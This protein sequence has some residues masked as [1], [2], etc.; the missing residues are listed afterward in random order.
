WRTDLEVHNPGSVQAAYTVG[1]LKRD[2]DNT[3][4]AVVSF[5]LAPGL[6]QRYTDI[7]DTV[8]H[9]S[10][11]A[12]LQIVV[13]SG[14]L[15]VASDTYNRLGAGNPGGLPEGSTYGQ[16][17]PAMTADQAI[18]SSDQ[19]RIIQLSHDPGMST[20]FRTNL[21]LVNAGTMP[22]A[23]TVE[24]Y[25]SGG[26]PLGATI[27]VSLRGL[28]Y[29][30]LD[31]VFEGVTGQVVS[32]GYAIVRTSTAGG[33][34]FAY[35]SV[36]DNRTGDPF[37]IPVAK[38]AGG[39]NPPTPTP[40]PAVPTPT[41]TPTVPTGTVI[42]GPGGTSVT[43]P[44]GGTTPNAPVTVTAGDGSN[45]TETGETLASTVIKVNVGG[46]GVS[47][48]AGPYL[49]KIPVTGTVSDPAKLELKVQTSVGSVYPVAGVY[50]AGSRTYTT[51]VE[52]LWNG[53]NMAIVVD[54]NLQVISSAGADVNA[55]GWVTPDD[56]QTCEWRAFRHTNAASA[57][58]PNEII[59]AIKP[60]CEHLRGAQFRSPK[61][62]IDTREAVK[63]RAVHIVAGGHSP[64][65]F[66]GSNAEDNAA[67]SLVHFNDEQM[68]SLG[69]LYFNWDE[70]Q[71]SIKAQGWSDGNVTMHE[72]LHAVQRG[73][74]IRDL[75]WQSGNV[76]NH[77]LM[78][79]MEGNS[80]IVGMNYQT[81]PNG[82]YGGDV[83]LRQLE[84]PETLDA[85]LQ[86]WTG[87]WAYARQDFFAYFAKRYNG[88]AF[89]DL[90]NL[91]QDLSEQTNGQFG[92]TFY[93]YETLY[94]QA[95]D[96]HYGQAF[97]V[98][99]PD[100]YTNFA[101]DRA[102]RHTDA[103]LLRDVD[104][105]LPKNSLDKTM[106][107]KVTAWDMA[108]KGAVTSAADGGFATGLLPLETWAITAPI[109]ASAQTA[110]GLPLVIQVKDAPLGHQGVRIFIFRE[111]DNVMM[112]NGEM[113]VTDISQPVA[114]PVDADTQSLTILVVNGSVANTPAQVS[115]G[116][117]SPISMY[118]FNLPEVVNCGDLDRDWGTWGLFEATWAGN[119]F[120]FTENK[121]ETD[122]NGTRR[123]NQTSVTG[124][125][126][127]DRK[128]LV[129]FQMDEH[130]KESYAPST[131]CNGTCYDEGWK[132]I[133]LAN[134]P[135]AADS[136]GM[137]F[138]YYAQ[139]APA[140]TMI[141]SWYHRS[142][143]SGFKY[144]DNWD[145]VYSLDD[146]QLTQF[147]IELK[148]AASP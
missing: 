20:N 118:S 115:I 104:K 122:E 13:T 45:L 2:T 96:I 120:S 139:G 107:T 38:L 82:I 67:F 146:S 3:N 130:W 48:G 74:D 106:F 109:P 30:Q 11:A 26:V 49:V 12:A 17:A 79:L 99:L 72:L 70:F 80:T 15:V 103:A 121:S 28:E 78:W 147:V 119:A 88:G 128:T 53:W 69:Q 40:T 85:M 43:L 56:W 87:T 22:I 111:K 81:N 4:P 102:Y 65:S 148:V 97:G 58:F 124:T 14:A 23:V 68:H 126:S 19:G 60:A 131:S 7:V 141:T 57:A 135:A 76:W 84:P 100:L 90:R 64:T 112:P 63:A 86:F 108:T 132:S 138:H 32:D 51:E 117:Y 52:R 127:A 25:S 114:V 92:K 47:T 39:P 6:S 105:G 9:F 31:K 50:D 44:S 42:T 35:A 95:M 24:L 61:L 62:W 91:Y 41:P 94:R 136:G 73:Y 93:D 145:C 89:R 5:M 59:Q 113:E 77:A 75:W 16:Y 140:R 123:D 46:E 133:K 137:Y 54:S 66:R 101:V 125:V 37:L 27:P 98:S 142:V 71:G 29:Q 34:F 8:F 83:T 21:G 36:I 18:T 134:V 10:G 116:I 143:Y 129:S 1:L 110:G 33:S 144:H 55:L